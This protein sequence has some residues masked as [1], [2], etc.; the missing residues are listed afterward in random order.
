MA[1][2]WGLVLALCHADHCEMTL[3]L[4]VCLHF[5]GHRN[6]SFLDLTGIVTLS[7]RKGKNNIYPTLHGISIIQTDQ[8]Y[9]ISSYTNYCSF[10]IAQKF[11]GENFGK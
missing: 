6:G 7:L 4:V 3:V 11:N 9:S 2:V 5:L 8:L 10:C 1:I